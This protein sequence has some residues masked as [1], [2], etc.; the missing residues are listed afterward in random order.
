MQYTCLV[1]SYPKLS[2]PPISELGGGSYEICPSCGFQF[3][4]DDEEEGWSYEKW[5]KLWEKEGRPW[6][7]KAIKQPKDWPPTLGAAP[8][9]PSAK[10]VAPAPVGKPIVDVDVVPWEEPAPKAKKAAPAAAKKTAPAKKVA[11]PAKK[12]VKKAPGKKK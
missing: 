10:T 12:A 1:C 2:E 9:K 8:A 3:G 6:R 5:R 4:F 11:A 7:S